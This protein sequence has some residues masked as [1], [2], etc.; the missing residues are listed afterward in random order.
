MVLEPM[1]AV[2]LLVE[3]PPR[4]QAK[5]LAVTVKRAHRGGDADFEGLP[6][7]RYFPK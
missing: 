2:R 4:V 1:E 5:A 3:L 6:G 7:V